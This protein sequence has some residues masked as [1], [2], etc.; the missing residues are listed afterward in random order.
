MVAFMTRFR[1]F[2]KHQR[3]V[4][5]LKMQEKDKPEGRPGG[6][7][8]ADRRVINPF[9]RTERVPAMTVCVCHDLP[10]WMTTQV[11]IMSVIA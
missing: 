9:F 10:T 6:A 3:L 4:P 7:A 8:G 2:L 5:G 11:T 1:S